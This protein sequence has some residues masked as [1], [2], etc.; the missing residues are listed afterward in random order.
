MA[1]REDGLGLS[2]SLGCP[3]IRNH[4]PPPPPPA[5]PF[6]LNFYRPPLPF[7]HHHQHQ[8][9]HKSDAFQQSDGKFT[10]FSI[11]SEI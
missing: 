6:R 4:D 11:Q 9:Q 1:E 3:E 8:H 7:M 10:V 2:L 5:S